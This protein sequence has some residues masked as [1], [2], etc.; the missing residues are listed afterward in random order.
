MKYLVILALFLAAPAFAETYEVKS[1]GHAFGH[2]TEGKSAK[3][4]CAQ[5]EGKAAKSLLEKCTAVDGEL[6]G[7]ERSF[8]LEKTPAGDWATCI[9]SLK[10]SCSADF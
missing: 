1:I 10:A 5:A 7:V 3:D 8:T 6:T 9:V 4:I 2:L